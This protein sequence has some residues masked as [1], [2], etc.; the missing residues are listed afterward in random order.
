MKYIA[1]I[2]HDGKKD[3]LVE[4]VSNNRE[5]FSKV[6]TLATPYHRQ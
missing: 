6:P 2:A 3:E 1:L 4:F 5:F